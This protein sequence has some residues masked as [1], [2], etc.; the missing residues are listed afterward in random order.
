MSDK[1]KSYQST[2]KVDAYKVT[3]KHGEDVVT[4]GGA[5]RASKGDYVVRGSDGSVRVMDSEAFGL[6]YRSAATRSA[7]KAV[8]KR[9][10]AQKPPTPP[11]AQTENESAADRVKAAKKAASK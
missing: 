7:R 1:F 4:S 10:E 5:V 3:D 8:A 9:T 6:A 2:E 11:V